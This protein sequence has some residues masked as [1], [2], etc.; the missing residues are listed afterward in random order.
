VGTYH[1][2]K[3]YLAKNVMRIF[4]L[5]CILV[6]IVSTHIYIEDNYGRYKEGNHEIIWS[7]SIPKMLLMLVHVILNK[8]RHPT[9]KC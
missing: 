9:I 8:L 2:Y 3:D 4:L 5:K 1:G 6:Y 7:E